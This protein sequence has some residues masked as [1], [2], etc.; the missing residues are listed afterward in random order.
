MPCS[1]GGIGGKLWLMPMQPSPIAETSRFC[2]SVRLFMSVSPRGN[3]LPGRWTRALRHAPG[4]RAAVVL[5]AELALVA[6]G[7]GRVDLPVADGERRLDSI[8]C[9]L[10]C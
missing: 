10:G 9:L 5:F 2:P 1:L 4:I 7:G 8:G 3:G 6:V